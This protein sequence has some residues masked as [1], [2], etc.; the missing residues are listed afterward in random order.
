[1]FPTKSHSSSWRFMALIILTESISSSISPLCPFCS[2]HF[3]L[4]AFDL[5]G[6]LLSLHRTFQVLTSELPVPSFI[7]AFHHTF[8]EHLRFDLNIA[9]IHAGLYLIY[10][11]ILEPVAAVRRLIISLLTTDYIVSTVALRST[12][13]IVPLNGDCVLS[14][15]GPYLQSSC[16]PWCFLDCPISRPWPGRKACSSTPR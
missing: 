1:M 12:N 5:L 15:F 3:H 14:R 16:P 8:N 9:S 2:G 7:P 11:F 6:Y 10:Y 4:P 13:D